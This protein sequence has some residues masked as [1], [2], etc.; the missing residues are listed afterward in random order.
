[1]TAAPRQSSV[2]RRK[3]ASPYAIRAGAAAVGIGRD[4]INPEAV[5]RRELDW[6]RELAG[7]FLVMVN[8]S[9]SRKAA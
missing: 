3:G 5:Q 9:R 8:D 2:D 4:L 7:R 6:I 1:M